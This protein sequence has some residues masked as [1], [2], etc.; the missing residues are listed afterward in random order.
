MVKGHIL[1]AILNSEKDV[2]RDIQVSEDM[3]LIDLNKLLL[4]V[5]DLDG[6][7]MASFYFSDDSWNEGEEIPLID[8][9]GTGARSMEN[10]TVID[11]FPKKG[12]RAIWVYDFITMQAFFIETIKLS[13][14][15]ATANPLIYSFGSMPTEVE[16]GLH[17]DSFDDDDADDD[18]DSNDIDDLFNEFGF[19]EEP[20]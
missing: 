6:G 4:T 2:F 13:E 3:G 12:S 19:D 18:Y 7:D 1:R 9:E 8:F 16:G 15:D 11:L 5:F 10:S 17:S 14:V 20:S